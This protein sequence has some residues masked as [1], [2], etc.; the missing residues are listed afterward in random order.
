MYYKQ[1]YVIFAHN[2]CK[3]G[4]KISSGDSA[5]C[6][7]IRSGFHRKRRQHT[8]QIGKNHLS[9]LTKYGDIDSGKKA[10]NGN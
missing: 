2:I 4:A 6:I 8:A 7:L 1:I 9:E 10:P 5:V 3:Y